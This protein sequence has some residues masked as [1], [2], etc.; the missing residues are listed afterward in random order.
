[1]RWHGIA[2]MICLLGSMNSAAQQAAPLP[3]GPK[4]QTGVIVGTVTDVNNDTVP[5]ATVVLDGPA[6]KTPRTLVTS[7]S[8]FFQF[9][10]VEPGTTYHV[11]VSAQG[12]A[13]W[14][15]AAVVLKPGQYLIL[16]GST[17]QIAQALTT[18]TVASAPASPE[19]IAKEQV[20]A[21]EQQ[22]IFGFIPNFYVSYDRNAAPLTA[23][24]KFKL[25][26]KVLFHPITVLGVAG[27]AGI[28]Q[29]ADNPNFPQGAKGYAERFGAGYADGFSDIMIGGAILPSLLH[30]D[31][32]YFYQGT[33]T[34]KS[35]ALHAVSSAFVCR[36]DNGRLQPN[37]S[38][39]GGDLASAAIAN[40]YYPESNRGAGLVFSNFFIG[41]GQ[42]ALANLAQ[43][44]LLHK[45]TSKPK[46]Q[47]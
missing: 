1:M 4:P 9:N 41:T 21:E 29:A 11:T 42:R 12:F 36:G 47:N 37:Y 24:L 23:K 38:T 6:L 34:N 25:A 2:L 3:E 7:D 26:A 31:P 19:E 30:Q 35:R 20:K 43:E 46:N 33:G 39:L 40:A 27:F 32:R 8:G 16:T 14:A 22:R 28:N 13:N 17:L 44:F 10:N 45:V 15:S 5:G 18:I